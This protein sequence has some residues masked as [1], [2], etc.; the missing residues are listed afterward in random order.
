MQKKKTLWWTNIY[1]KIACLVHIR[2]HTSEYVSILY[3]IYGN[4]AMNGHAWCVMGRSRFKAERYIG[5]VVEV[6]TYKVFI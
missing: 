4:I 6:V 1:I 3:D 5:T 2:Y